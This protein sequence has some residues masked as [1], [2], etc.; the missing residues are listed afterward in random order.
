MG[1]FHYHVPQ[2]EEKKSNQC[3]DIFLEPSRSLLPSYP[4]IPLSPYPLNP[5]T[6]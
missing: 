1:T 5:S 6:P 2:Y 4:P 3:M